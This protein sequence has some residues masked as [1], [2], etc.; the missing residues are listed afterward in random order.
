MGRAA[1]AAGSHGLGRA[2]SARLL[3]CAMLLALL[4]AAL[5]ASTASAFSQRGHEFSASFP[6]AGEEPALSH[7]TDVAID[8]ATGD[9]YVVD[10]A[11]NRVVVYDASHKFIAA[12][13][14]G[15]KDEK[16]EFEVCTS[17]CKAGLAGHKP[18]QFEAPGTIAV[19]NSGGPSEGDVYVEAVTPSFEVEVATIDKFSGAEPEHPTLITKFNHGKGGEKFEA[20]NGIAVGPE[21]DLFV[22]NEQEIFGFGNEV[23]SKANARYEFEVAGE[24]TRGFAVAPKAGPKGGFYVG[25]FLN[26]EGSAVVIAKEE[27]FEEEKELFALPLNEALDAENSTGVASD[28]S[29]E[30]AYVDHGKTVAAFDASGQPIQSFGEEAGSEHISEGAGLAVDAKTGEVLVAD[31]GANRID[32]FTLEK[33]G[34]APR[35]DELSAAATTATTTTLDAEVDPAGSKTEYAFRYSPGAVPAAGEPCRPAVRPDAGGARR[36][37]LRIRR[38]APRCRRQRPRA[39]DDV[40]LQALGSNEAN[41]GAFVE[42]EAQLKTLSEV[43]GETLPDGRQWQQVSPVEKNAG[44]LGFQNAATSTGGQAEASLDGTGLTYLAAGAIRGTCAGEEEPAG[45]RSPEVTQMLSRRGAAGWCSA[46]IETKHNVAEGLTP[47]G[48]PEYR[49]FSEDLS[50]SLVE[51]FGSLPQENPPLSGEAAERTPYLRHNLACA[52]EPPGCF[53]PLATKLNVESGATYGGKVHYVAATPDMGHI[54]VTSTVALNK[55]V[56]ETTNNL[57]AWSGGSF[58]LINTFPTGESSKNTPALGFSEGQPKNERR[59]ISSDGSRY[60]WTTGFGPGSGHLY[61]RDLAQARSVRLDVKSPSI[62]EGSKC[63]VSA[64]ACEHARFQ[65][66]SADGSVVFFTSEQRLTTNSGANELQPD[67][68]ACNVTEEEVEVEGRSESV[69]TGCKLTDLTPKGAGASPA[70]PRASRSGP[71]KQAMSSTSSPTARSTASRRGP[72]KSVRPKTRK[73]AARAKRCPSPPN[74]TCSSPATTPAAKRGAAPNP[75]SGSP[76]KTNSTGLRR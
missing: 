60:V 23:E 8:E 2:A 67:L 17:A 29:D 50:S 76:P 73:R 21:G 40:Q 56:S 12:W 62:P 1:G 36:S 15:V 55:E 27:A 9:V 66:A 19:D 48:P 42:A 32:A 3:V 25:Q 58:K 22:S 47:G 71:A 54:V 10:S 59:A 28:Y 38:R 46:D 61:L 44:I 64:A 16:K 13:G 39:L 57:Y 6:A 5:L 34:H 74:A 26:G 31:A 35:I 45:A 11:N 53:Q 4:A 51:A 7:P 20:P 63:T 37:G 18:G 41:P 49:A 72:A 33:A 43:V 14:F 75:S 30:D 24:A 68:Y 65:I 70:P 52:G 69:P